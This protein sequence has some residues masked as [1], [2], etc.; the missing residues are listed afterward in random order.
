MA[1]VDIAENERWAYSIEEVG[2]ML[3][4]G[5]SLMHDLLALG[6][7]GS[8]KAGRRTLITRKHLSKFLAGA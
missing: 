5:K 6:K 3:G 2:A 7:I 8:I 1:E 4:L